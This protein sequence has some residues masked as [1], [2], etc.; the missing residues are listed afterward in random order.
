MPHTYGE[1]K[2]KKRKEKK[3]QKH[4]GSQCRRQRPPCLDVLILQ[5]KQRSTELKQ[6]WY[7]LA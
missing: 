4:S 7:K 2:K 5:F 1:R 6:K 3:K